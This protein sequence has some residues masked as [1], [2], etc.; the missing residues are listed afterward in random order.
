MYL[1][2]IRG[3]SGI[4]AVLMLGG[5][6]NGV[7]TWVRPRRNRT[8][9]IKERTDVKEYSKLERSARDRNCWKN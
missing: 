1:H 3:N 4:N 9:Y 5:K 7:R 6:I 8:D 2:V